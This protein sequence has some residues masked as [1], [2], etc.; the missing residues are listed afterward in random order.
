MVSLKPIFKMRVKKTFYG[1]Q[2]T[3]FENDTVETSVRT[4][5][6]ISIE[7]KNEDGHEQYI[8]LDIPTAICFAKEFRKAINLSKEPF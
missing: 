2:S 7:I 1:V 8:V 6:T 3:S 5:K 4:D